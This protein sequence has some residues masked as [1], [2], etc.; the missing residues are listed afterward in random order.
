MNVV[1]RML[2]MQQLTKYWQGRGDQITCRKVLE[3]LRGNVV[4][5]GTMAV[6]R[7]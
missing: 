7:K 2:V 4:G 3:Q 1:N 5:A 6:E